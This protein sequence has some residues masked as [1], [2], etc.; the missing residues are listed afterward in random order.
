LWAPP[1]VST[2]KSIS[3]QKPLPGFSSNS[4]STSFQ[5]FNRGGTGGLGIENSIRPLR[6]ITDRDDFVDHTESDNLGFGNREN[7]GVSWN[8]AG[9]VN[10][11]ATS[12]GEISNI[13]A[14]LLEQG[15]PKRKNLVDMIQED[16]PRTPSPV[17]AI[18]QRQ[19]AI[20]RQLNSGNVSEEQKKELHEQLREQI[21]AERDAL[22]R[23]TQEEEERNHV[24][25][26]VSAALDREELSASPPMRSASTPPT[27]LRYNEL[28]TGFKPGSALANEYG[29]SSANA[30]LLNGMR[31][32]SLANVSITAIL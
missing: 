29:P 1:G 12:N 19:M 16:F 5:G 28:R 7:R 14:R 4:N 2:A 27:Q 18:Q 8:T 17:Y 31:G 21:K 26:V 6:N 3:P 23:Q 13:S 10:A 30:I 32:M 15:S 25:S 22:D 9:G 24:A 20:Q 11:V